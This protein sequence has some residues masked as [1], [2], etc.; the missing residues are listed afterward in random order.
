[1]RLLLASFLLATASLAGAQAAAP[2]TATT[3]W[4]RAT[5]QGQR[6]SAAYVTLTASE[7]LV[8]VGVS[9]PAAGASEIHEMK[10][11]GD[12][13]RMRAIESLALAPGKPVELKPGGL[14]LMLQGLKAPLAANTSIPVTLTFRTAKGEARQLALQVPVT[15]TPPKESGAASAHQ[16]R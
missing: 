6:A 1:M 8:L 16:H 11:E 4:A 3:P 7:P 15:A 13:M 2:V 14:H 12:V 5:V 10:L 9:S